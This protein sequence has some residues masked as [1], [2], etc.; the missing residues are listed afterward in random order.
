MNFFIT[1][2]EIIQPDDGSPE[3]IR[4]DGRERGGENLRFGTYDLASK[5]FTLYSE[6][7][8]DADMQYNGLKLKKE[9]TL[10][11]SA[12][13]FKS[14]YGQLT[15]SDRTDV[16]FFI[17]G[18]NTNLDDVRT[19]F[20]TLNQK[21]VVAGSPIKHII[22]FTWPGRSPKIPLH[23]RDDA[24]DAK[25]SGE[26]LA[27]SFE[28]VMIFLN[29]FLAKGQNKPCGQHIHLM[30]HSMGHRVVKN[31]LLELERKQLPKP[32]IFK[33]ILLMAADTHYD[34]FTN[35][36]QDLI[37]LG[38]RIH[39]YYHNKD[40]VLWI[41]KYTKNFSNRLGRNGRKIKDPKLAY[42]LEVDCTK[43]KDDPEYGLMIDEG[44]HWY[45][46]SA[47]TVVND[48]IEVLLHN[49]TELTTR[50]L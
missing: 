30:V 29:Q 47:T 19:A 34:V 37:D 25:T 15:Q 23:Y 17:H 5:D 35:S 28:K 21:Y 33:E 3:Y 18:F 44:N 36:Y 16:L 40:Q 42:I 22:I 32:M 7:D 27:R 24:K 13:F 14:I 11:G 46:Y 39:I 8:K 1:N 12:R 49:N 9:Q 6:P 26:A 38:E 50:T 41:S 43:V 4:E 31:M 48:V 20:K 45:Y 10:K 2:R